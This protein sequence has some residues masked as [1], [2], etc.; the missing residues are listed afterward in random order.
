M[1]DKEIVNDE[2]KIPNEG[3]GKATKKTA[4]KEPV[5]ASKYV[6]TWIAK[7]TKRV[8]QQKFDSAEEAIKA[9]TK[10]GTSDPKAEEV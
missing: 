10:I 8:S 2:P 6:Y 7:G 9:A 3:K 4:K 1:S 5:K